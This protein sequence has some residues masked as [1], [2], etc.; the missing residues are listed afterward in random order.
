MGDHRRL[1]HRPLGVS[2][3]EDLVACFDLNGLF[4]Y[5]NVGEIIESFTRL[6]TYLLKGRPVM[7][8]FHHGGSITRELLFA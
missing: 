6:N 5:A 3:S 1:A 4:C 2:F 8:S 7:M